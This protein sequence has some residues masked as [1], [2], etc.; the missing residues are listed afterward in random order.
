[1]FI[2]SI[3]NQYHTNLLYA[4]LLV[5]DL[6]EEQMTHSPG[7]GL[8]NHPAWT[9]G[10]LIT[11][12]VVLLEDLGSSF[13]IPQEWTALFLRTGPGDPRL[14]AAETNSYPSKQEL[15]TVYEQVHLAVTSELQSLSD[16]DLKREYNWRFSAH[17]PN[18]GDLIMFMCVTHEAMH[19]G[20]LGAWRRAMGLESALAKI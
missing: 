14:P 16:E 18:L 2:D 8:E 15:L 17:Q 19:L 3:L 12:S 1:M 13:S 20:Q 7:K 9:I 5:E 11:G 4:Q 10:H 6:N